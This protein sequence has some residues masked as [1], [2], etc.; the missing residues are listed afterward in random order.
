MRGRQRCGGE[1][2]PRTP[3]SR[4]TAGAPTPQECPFDKNAP[5]ER[6][7]APV[8]QSVTAVRGGVVVR[9]A[10]ARTLPALPPL[11]S[12][13]GLRRFTAGAPKK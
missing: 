12:G 2:A 4:F 10:G 1:D 3:T 7:E 13:Q 11:A 8:S 6:S 9:D 5:F